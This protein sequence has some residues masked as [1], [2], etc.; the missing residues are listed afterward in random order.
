MQ[1]VSCFPWPRRQSSGPYT[2][3]RRQSSPSLHRPDM[4]ELVLR[5]S[6]SERK[7]AK[8]K[9]KERRE[10]ALS[11]HFGEK[12]GAGGEGG[13]SCPEDRLPLLPISVIGERTEP[14]APITPTSADSAKK[15]FKW[16]IKARLPFACL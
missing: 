13:G 10:K 14:P 7:L 11:V 16:N 12:A 9:K 5:Q 6:S 15:K 8:E 1:E 3:H 2:L 4:K